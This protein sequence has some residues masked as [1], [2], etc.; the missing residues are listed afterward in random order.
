MHRALRAIREIGVRA[1]M[2]PRMTAQLASVY[3]AAGRADEGLEVLASS[4]DR[5][6]GQRPVRYSE[7]YRI[8]GD[9]HGLKSSPDL[10]LAEACY[11]E[12]MEVAVQDEAKTFE[13][14]SATSLARLWKSQGRHSEAYAL[15]API[16]T[17]FS[18]GFGFRDL[19]EAAALLDA[20]EIS[21]AAVRGVGTRAPRQASRSQGAAG[22][23]CRCA[24][25]TP[26]IPART[27]I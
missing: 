7:I 16:Y 22:V 20:Q 4:P 11:R 25:H 14:R 26:K 18:E 9:L 3:A 19:R 2:A 6:P 17:W 1:M 21:V 15:L 23:H 13:L 27:V 12:A 5:Q 10:A 24:L 8:E